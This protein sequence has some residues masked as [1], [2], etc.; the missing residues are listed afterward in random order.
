MSDFAALAAK[1][2]EE[3]PASVAEPAAADE[4]EDGPVP[5]VR[6]HHPIAILLCY[7]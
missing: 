1:A 7:L 2:A 3:K 5:E 6:A 4:D